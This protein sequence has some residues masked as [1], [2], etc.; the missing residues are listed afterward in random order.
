MNSFESKEKYLKPDSLSDRQPVQLYKERRSMVI[1]PGAGNQSSSGVL[2]QLQ[3]FDNT[4]RM[5]FNTT[6]CK[7]L[8]MSK[9]RSCRKPL[10][11]YNLGE[12]IL[13]HSPETSDLG[14]SVSGNCTW[15]SHIEQMCSK[16]KRILGLVKRL[17]GRDIRDV[18]TRKLLYTALVRPL[19]EYSSS[20]W[21][22]YFVKHRRL[23]ENI[24][25]RATKFIL[26]Y[27]PRE[28]SYIN[29]LDQ[30][31]LLPI[32]FLRQMH[33]LV[34]LF[35]LRLELLL[36]ILDVSFILLLGI[37]EPVI[38]IKPTLTYFLGTIRNIIV[39]AIFQGQLSCG[40]AYL[41]YSSLA[42]ISCGLESIFTNT[43][44]VYY[45]LTVRH[46]LSITFHTTFF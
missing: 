12:E 17:C 18:Q 16:A 20:V 33:D 5:T 21:S 26:N 42:R 28:V 39:T 37:I 44:E 36:V 32:D 30:L 15:T 43:L 46:D 7:V 23:I 14:V 10:N 34:L 13:L 1:F 40:T 45:K 19:L 31:N 41:I 2:N 29:R 22:P 4:L 6:K 11:T 3:F 9:R 27:P 25:R 35:K 8:R 24:Q 38:F